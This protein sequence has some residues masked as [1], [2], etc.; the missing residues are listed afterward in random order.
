[1]ELR[2]RRQ[3]GSLIDISLS[4]APLRD[5]QGQIIGVIGIMEDITEAKR[6]RQQLLQS[7]RMETVGRLAGGVA[8]DFNNLLAV[9]SGYSESLL[10]R[11]ADGDP[12][13]PPVEEIQKAADRGAALTRQLLAFS[14]RQVVQAQPLDLAH[15][16]SSVNQM[17]RRV[18]SD[19]IEVVV[20]NDARRTIVRGDPG[21]MEQVLVNLALNARDAMPDGGVLSIATSDARLTEGQA[22]A[23]NLKPGRYVKLE[24]RDTGCGM[25][26]EVRSRIFEPF[27]TT[28]DGK[29]T[30]L[31]LSIVYG[32]V[33]QC[34]GNISV[35]SEPGK[36]TRFSILLPAV[37]EDG[38]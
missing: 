27:Y 25:D 38:A 8:H 35:S 10:R 34:G 30:G 33:Q 14:R 3:N 24:V 17:L 31:G 15:V 29:G 21:Q 6:L 23:V 4:A 9:I 13:R 12:L 18:I 22:T 32:I 20:R 28:K 36:G 7:H 11:I 5:G 1:V 19:K 16:V 2:R 26:E 37:R